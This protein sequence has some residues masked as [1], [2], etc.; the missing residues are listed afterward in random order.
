MSWDR[1][2]QNASAY[3][4]NSALVLMW[5][6]Q[7]GYRCHSNFPPVLGASAFH[8]ACVPCGGWE[9]S[10]MLLA[11]CRGEEMGHRASRSC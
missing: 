10:L 1:E 9:L 11:L 3:V 6:S 5:K 4:L 7:N 2:E 8:G